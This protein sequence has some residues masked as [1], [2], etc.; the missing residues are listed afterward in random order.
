MYWYKL[1]NVMQKK[2]PTGG[3]LSPVENNSIKLGEEFIMPQLDRRN[4]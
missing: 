2:K 1:K 4:Q 3:R